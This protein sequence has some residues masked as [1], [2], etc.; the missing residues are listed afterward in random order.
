MSGQGRLGDKANVP[1]DAHGCPACPHPGTG[2]AIFGSS[3]VIVNGRSA[4]RLGDPG[5]H[6]A[7]C[8]MNTWKADAGSLTVFINGKPSHRMSDRTRHCGGIGQLIEGSPNVIVGGGTSSGGGAGGASAAGGAGAGAASGAGGAGAGAAG[9]AGTGATGGAAGGSAGGIAGPGDSV[10]SGSQGSDSSNVSGQTAPGDAP[11][12]PTTDAPSTSISPE[13]IEVQIV[14]ALGRPQPSV[15][16]D[17]A[18]PDGTTK[19]GSTAAD[20]YLRF[21]GIE[22]PGIAK[23]VLPAYDAEKGSASGPRTSGAQLYRAGGVDVAVGQASIVELQPRVYR[24]R[25]TGFLFDTDRT[26]VKPG[27]LEGIRLVT[28]MYD[29]HPGA[30]VLVSG[31]ADTVGDPQY[32]RG[33]SSERAES[34]AAFLEDDVDTWLAWYQGKPSSHPWGT[35]EDQYMLATIKDDTGAPFYA[36]PVGDGAGPQ[37]IEA[38]QRYQQARGL[39]V[40]GACGPQTRRALIT[41]YMATDGTTLPAGTVIETHGCGESHPADPIGDN[42]SDAENRRVEVF[43]FEGPIDPP[44]VPSCPIPSGC[45]EYEQWKAKTVQSLELRDE[46]ASIM[47]TVTDENDAA[48]DGASVHASGPTSANATTSAGRASIRDIAAGHY[49]LVAKKEGFLDA[50]VEV[51]AAA[52]GVSVQIDML[53]ALDT[54]AFTFEVSVGGDAE[55]PPPSED[56]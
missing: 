1:V 33:L 34:V 22:T 6:A 36:G 3:D 23:L 54:A 10:T 38:T 32:N 41:D 44:P 27:A 49:V 4:L 17:L 46:P 45:A 53:S 13:Q 8:A 47:I 11:S 43:F 25:L 26:F 24:G 7:C 20:G 39:A 29:E 12:A 21:S 18:M 31:H 55:P 5:V 56:A 30:E 28:R 48:V 9:G 14:D 2:P 42:Q 40:D 35:R 19:S 51:D 15:S 37:V 16:F 50:T 52:G